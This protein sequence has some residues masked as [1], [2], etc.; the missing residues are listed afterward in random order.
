[1]QDYVILAITVLVLVISALLVYVA[2]RRNRPTSDDREE[3]DA[4]NRMQ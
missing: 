1:M 3:R 4:D 2:R